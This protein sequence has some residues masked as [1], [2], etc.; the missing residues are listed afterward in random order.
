MAVLETLSIACGWIYIACW[1][2]FPYPQLYLNWKLRSVR[3]LSLDSIFIDQTLGTIPY[4]IFVFS[5]Y[6]VR[7]IKELYDEKHGQVSGRVL[8]DSI[9]TSCLTV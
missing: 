6:W 1:G 4:A 7:P 3:G 8:G 5:L 9:P 2:V